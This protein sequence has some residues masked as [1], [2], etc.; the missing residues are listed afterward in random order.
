MRMS[1]ILYRTFQ[2][3]LSLV[4]VS[5]VAGSSFAGTEPVPEKS[6]KLSNKKL[7][8]YSIQDL[9][10][11]YI[12]ADTVDTPETSEAP[13]PKQYGSLEPELDS[14]NMGSDEIEG[15]EESVVLDNDESYYED[16]E[17]E[18]SSESIISFNFLYYLLQKFKFSNSLQ[19]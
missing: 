13:P 8:T 10:S 7:I 12:A 3:V 1:E 16:D 9:A 14:F 19:Y 11:T 6:S 15:E 2:L 17:A 4:C 5:I 18:E